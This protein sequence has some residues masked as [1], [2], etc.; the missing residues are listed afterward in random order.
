MQ[1]TTSRRSFLRNTAL[2]TAGAVAFKPASLLF[3]GPV[4][5]H[6]GVQLYSVRTDIAKDPI[7]T[8]Q[9]IAKAGY[10][11]VEGYGMDVDKIFGMSFSEYG[12]VLKD[13]GLKM[14]SSH[15]GVN[16]KHY[17][18]TTK[19]ITDDM[20]K[21]VDGAAKLGMKYVTCPFMNFNERPEIAKL[22][23]VFQAMGEYCRKAGVRFAYHNHDFEYKDKGPDGRLI[24]EWLLQEI[25]PK[26]MAMEM[27][28]Y[29]VA[30]AN[31]NPLDWFRLYPGRWELCH[32]KDMA[33]TEKQETV[34][35]GDGSIDFKNIFRQSRQAGLQYYIVELEHYVT[36][37]LAGVDKAR[38][39]LLKT[40]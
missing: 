36:T 1:Y 30:K 17:N 25:D 24:T 5:A 28:I 11:E 14:P 8:T 37:P 12:K 20:K 35:V 33:K 3:D 22:V 31:H 38:K 21:I 2:A 16:L 6:I 34:E 13:N 18:E 19:E 39:G 15:C 32:A 9:A 29:W 7:A 26:L 40:F 10:R 23:K 4:P 27:D